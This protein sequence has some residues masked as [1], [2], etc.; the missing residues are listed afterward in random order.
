MNTSGVSNKIKG[1]W[2]QV[3][4]NVNK[5]AGKGIKG[6]W[7]NIQGKVQEGFGDAQMK[8]NAKNSTKSDK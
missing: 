4:G 6:G 1:K 2:K 3:E 8:D 7:Q 5:Q